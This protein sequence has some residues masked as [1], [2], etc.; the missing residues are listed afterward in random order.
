M[1]D[2]AAIQARAHG[3]PAP[4]LAL[5]LCQAVE[6]LRAPG[7]DDDDVIQM[8]LARTDMSLAEATRAMKLVRLLVTGEAM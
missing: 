7:D 8:L 1:I 5:Y 2:P 3:M 6:A 4:E